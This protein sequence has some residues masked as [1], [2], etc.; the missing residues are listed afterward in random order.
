M[1]SLF[2][3]LPLL[4]SSFIS[5]ISDWPFWLIVLLVGF[6]Y[7]RMARMSRQLFD[8]PEGPIW[9]SVLIVTLFG[10]AGGLL[11]SLLIIFTG[12]SVLE[13]GINY[14]WLTAIALMLIQQR[15][16]C[17]AYAGGVLSLMKIFLGFPAISVAQVMGLVAILHM[18]EALLI[19]FSGHLEPLPVYVRTPQGQIVGGYN[20]QKFWPLPLVALLAALIPDPQAAQGVVA[21]PDWWPLIKTELLTGQ[22]EPLYMLMPVVAALGYGDV[23][24]TTTPRRKTRRAALEL[25]GYSLVLLLL[26]VLASHYS[27]YPIVALLPAL[28]GPLGHE[29]L[30]Y[31]GQK[32][33]M[34]GEPLYVPS[35]VGLKVLHVFPASPLKKAGVG[36]GDV[37]LALNGIPFDNMVQLQEILVEAGDRLLLEF[38]QEKTGVLK[39]AVLKRKPGETLGFVPVPAWH[40]STYLEVRG[41]VSIARRWWK[42]LQDM[43]R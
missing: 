25:G 31:L 6:Q 34:S 16:L 28:F 24:I 41:S 21:M 15:F 35:P 12:I 22:G 7:R 30:I 14:L 36:D 11:G 32:R 33:E 39:K 5:L 2:D 8:L 23:A 9:P 13:I 29:L 43:F 40:N 18:V 3:L 27:R 17:F 37:L 1:S 20:L 4:I 38:R 19:Y 10:M 26:A 42:R